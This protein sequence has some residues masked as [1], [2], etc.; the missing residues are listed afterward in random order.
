[1]TLTELK[2]KYGTWTNMS[3]ELHFGQ[4]TYQRWKQNGRIPMRT[5]KYI[6]KMTDGDLVAR[7]VDAISTVPGYE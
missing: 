1:M 6:Q 2:E 4:N 7:D 3:R 5:Q